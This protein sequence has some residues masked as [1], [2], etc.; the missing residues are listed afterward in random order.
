MGREVSP[1]ISSDVVVNKNRIISICVH[2]IIIFL[3][4][5]TRQQSYLEVCVGYSVLRLADYLAIVLLISKLTVQKHGNSTTH[6]Y[7][8]FAMT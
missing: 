2:I 1:P 3:A 8:I 4:G 5:Q 6:F 7:F